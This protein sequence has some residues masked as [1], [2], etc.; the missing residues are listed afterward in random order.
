MHSTPSERMDE[1]TRDLESNLGTILIKMT[2]V[3]NAY[4]DR[5]ERAKGLEIG[6]VDD[7]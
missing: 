6:V 1:S 5:I 2:Y 4:D 3:G 7:V